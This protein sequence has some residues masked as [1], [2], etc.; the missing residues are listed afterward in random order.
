MIRTALFIALAVA[1]NACGNDDSDSSSE[2]ALTGTWVWEESAQCASA[3]IFEDDSY[4][5][6]RV[7]Q[8]GSSSLLAQVTIGTYA[9]DGDSLKLTPKES[10]CKA[11]SPVEMAFTVTDTKLTLTSGSAAVVLIRSK[12]G[13]EDEEESFVMVTGCFD[14]EGFTSRKIQELK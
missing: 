2:P 4:S 1:A 6:Q 8:D 5:T 3:F 12:E 9:T 10:S 11:R 7:C 14:D 13:D